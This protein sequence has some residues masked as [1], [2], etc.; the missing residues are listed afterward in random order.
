[1]TAPTLAGT[2]AANDF[3]DVVGVRPFAAQPNAPSAVLDALLELAPAT[4]AR[5]PAAVTALLTVHV[6]G[7]IA[8]LAL[9]IDGAI[10]TLT[11]SEPGAHAALTVGAT[12]TA[13]ACALLMLTLVARHRVRAGRPSAARPV[14]WATLAT[15]VLG[16]P[17]AW[18]ALGT[19]APGPFVL[20]AAAVCAGAGWAATRWARGASGSVPHMGQS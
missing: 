5:T 20:L 19:R 7:S 1:M 13:L 17:V 16:A 14:A 9:L 4:P 18:A 3:W 2:G 6:A 11:G 15:G 12:A 10:R 8:A